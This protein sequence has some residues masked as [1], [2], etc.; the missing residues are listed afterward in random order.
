MDNKLK[1]ARI[2]LGLFMLVGTV[3]VVCG[4][5][6]K[7]KLKKNGDTTITGNVDAKHVVV[8]HDHVVIK[9]DPGNAKYTCRMSAT[10]TGPHGENLCS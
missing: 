10:V 4:A 2:W 6:D 7:I 5:N 3:D 9:G 1:N 8:S